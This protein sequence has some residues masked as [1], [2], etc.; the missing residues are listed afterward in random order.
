MTM[1]NAFWRLTAMMVIFLVTGG[2]CTLGS[3]HRLGCR[4][5]ARQATNKSHCV[6]LQVPMVY[7]TCKNEILKLKLNTSAYDVT[8]YRT[9]GFQDIVTSIIGFV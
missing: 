8:F 9:S 1:N 4:K 5:T 2:G 6:M 3:F 7:K